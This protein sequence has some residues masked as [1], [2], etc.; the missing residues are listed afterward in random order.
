MCSSLAAGLG[1][2]GRAGF[3]LRPLARLA[4]AAP[5]VGAQGFGEA[6]LAIRV[7]AGH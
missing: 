5:Q 1:L 6:A 3:A 2:G 7:F 4:F